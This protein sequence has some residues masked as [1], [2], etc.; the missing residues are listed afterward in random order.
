MTKI[1][2]TSSSTTLE[3]MINPIAAAC[4]QGYI[5]TDLHFLTNPGITDEVDTA[6]E[7]AKTI[8]T[9]YGG[10]EPT[11]HINSLDE[12]TAFNQIYDHFRDIIQA[13]QESDAD[14]AVDIT[15]GRKFMSAIA[16]ATGLRYDADHVFY[17]YMNSSEY[18]GD[19]Y[20]EMPRSATR[21]Y[22]FTEVL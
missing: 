10:D 11:A 7:L 12:D 19:S 15:P 1:W 9:E 20:P 3:A 22:D 17:F 2:V 14:V 8:I 18:F 4:E 6:T 5:P 16:F 21:L 13:S